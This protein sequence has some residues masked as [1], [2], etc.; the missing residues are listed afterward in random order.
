MLEQTGQ[1]YRSEV[2]LH[3]D[4]LGYEQDVLVVRLVQLPAGLL[5]LVDDVVQLTP[6]PAGCKSRDR[7]KRTGVNFNNKQI[8]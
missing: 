1:Q 2:L 7:A 4:R 8:V 5:V 6:G 3:L